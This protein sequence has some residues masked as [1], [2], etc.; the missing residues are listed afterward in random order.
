MIT[1]KETHIGETNYN[2]F[3]TLMKIVEYKGWGNIVVEFQDE[4]KYRKNTTYS[5]FKTGCIKNPYD[6]TVYGIAWIGEG[7]YLAKENGYPTKVYT[8]WLHLIERCCVERKSD[9]YPSYYGKCEVCEEWLEFQVFAKWYFTNYY[10]LPSGER[11]HLDKDILFAGN[12]LYCPERCL[13]VPQ[14]INMF[15]MNKPNKRGLPNGIVKYKRG[16][17]AKYRHKELGVYSTIQEAY[18]VYSKEKKENIIRA[19]KEYKDIIPQHV[20]E[21]IL[22][23]KIDIENDKNYVA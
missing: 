12:K 16:Y 23:C 11:L 17:L 1:N 14:K 10:D 6:K 18:E 9:V 21:A 15:F 3:G 13:F 7:K 4:H 2:N 5:N 8:C 22:N 19:A 20:Y